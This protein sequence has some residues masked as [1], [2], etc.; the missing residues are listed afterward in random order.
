MTMLENVEGAIKEAV[1]PTEM[2]PERMK[3][4]LNQLVDYVA[5]G[6][7]TKETIEELMKYGF[8][9]EELVLYFNFSE[10]DVKD[11][12]GDLEYNKNEKLTLIQKNLDELNM[13]QDSPM[14]DTAHTC[15][16]RRDINRLCDELGMEL[17]YNCSKNQYYIGACEAA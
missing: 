11:V 5:I 12:A 17:C 2:K 4:L 15:K 16:L 9:A 6:N 7:D 8:T 13:L 14:A 1:V 10:N 3:E